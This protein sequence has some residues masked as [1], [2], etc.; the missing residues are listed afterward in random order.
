M[1]PKRDSSAGKLPQRGIEARY[2]RVRRSQLYKWN[3]GEHIRKILAKPEQFKNSTAIQT[4]NR[5]GFKC[6]RMTNDYTTEEHVEKRNYASLKVR[7]NG[8]TRLSKRRTSFARSVKPDHFQG[9]R[10]ANL[11]KIGFYAKNPALLLVICHV[12]TDLQVNKA[13]TEFPDRTAT[14]VRQDIKVNR[15]T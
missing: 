15:V 11:G 1:H 7:Q 8:V 5:I 13:T 9:H 14:P 4:G 2:F 6:L 10:G 3:D 12:W